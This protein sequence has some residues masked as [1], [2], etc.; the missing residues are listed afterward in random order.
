MPIISQQF[1][2]VT[3]FAAPAPSDIIWENMSVSPEH[4]ENVAYVSSIFYYTGESL[5]ELV[6]CVGIYCGDRM[7]VRCSPVENGLG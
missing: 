2:K 5:C 7:L 1:P 3:A 4:T 6:C